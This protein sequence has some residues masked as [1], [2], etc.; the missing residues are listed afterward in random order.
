MSKGFQAIRGMN[1]IL[2][3]EVMVWQHVEQVLKQAAKQYGYEE[4]R[5]PVL[6]NTQLFKRTIGNETDI[7]NK[8][9]YTFTDKNDEGV[10]LRPEG[11]AGCVR[12][13]IQRGLLYNQ[14]QR[15]WY[16][17]PMFRRERPQRGRLRQFHQFGA[18]Y[19]GVAN[20]RA[21]AELISLAHSIFKALNLLPHLRLEINSLGSQESRKAY[22]K[23][24]IDY[25]N[26]HKSELDEDSLMR[27]ERNNPL[28]ILDSKN[29]AM[30]SLIQHAPTTESCMDEISTLHFTRVQEYLA[31]MNI[32]YTVNP[33]L[34]RGLDYYDHTAFEWI[35]DELGAQGTV[36]GGGRYNTLVET[37]GG[38][39]T[40]A[41]GFAMGLERLVDLLSQQQSNA[42]LQSADIYCI[43]IGEA[44]YLYALTLVQ[45]IR[46]TFPQLT[47]MI[48]Q[49]EDKL[50]NQFKQAD[51]SGAELALIL[52]EEECQAGTVT[53]KELKN[54]NAEQTAIKATDLLAAIEKKITI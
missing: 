9:M 48:N 21:D 44:A 53:I 17:G 26:S 5:F 36:C 24:L 2:P 23:V 31:A 42:T 38:K 35:S 19:L 15:L 20:P 22:N 49:A 51:K 46:Q 13:G 12:A 18:E 7:V 27:L 6:E 1:D 29:P 39:P 37:L 40:P 16:L 54:R 30:K 4:I 52:G 25:F 8:E 34:V 11:T 45:E 28:R 32:E 14:Q 33:Y 47:V 3:S 43:T 41:V 10:S 50:K